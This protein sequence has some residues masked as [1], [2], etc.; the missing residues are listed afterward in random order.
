[1]DLPT[2][3]KKTLQKKFSKAPNM[4]SVNTDSVWKVVKEHIKM[5]VA[6]REQVAWFNDFYLDKIQNG[7][8]YFISTSNLKRTWIENNHKVLIKKAL[9]EATG[10]NLTISIQIHK[11]SFKQDTAT[12]EIL[13][14]LETKSPSLFN[15]TLTKFRKFKEAQNKAGLRPEYTMD[16]FVVGASNSIAFASANAVVDNPGKVYNPVFIYGKTGVGKTHLMQAVGNKLLKNNSSLKIKYCSAEQF[17]ED[18]ITAIR[19]NSTDVFRKEYR[20]LDIWLIDD[21]QFITNSPKT[22]EE[23]FHTFNAL[24]SQ[25]KQVILVSDT[26]PKEIHGLVERL[27]SRFE[28]GLVVDIQAPDFETRMAILKKYTEQQGVKVPK[29]Y[30]EF[31]ANNIESNIRQLEGAIKKITVQ[32][33]YAPTVFTENDLARILGVDINTKRKKISPDKVINAVANIFELHP[34]EIRGQ[35]RTAYVSLARQTV[36]CILRNELEYPLEKVAKFVNRKDHTTVLHACEKIENKMES[37]SSFVDKVKTCISYL[38][39]NL[40]S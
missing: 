6:Q 34:K 3:Y 13:D 24:Y 37:E 31:I 20:G 21:V 10:Q 19:T 11:P 32:L 23:L 38:E 22:Q 1:M 25:N 14:E 2:E 28:G 39:E 29:E 16:E 30:M 15:P 8:A 4:G 18:F 27:K 26:P 17:K 35:K 12:D 36:M 33:K 5:H 40:S 9:K 7:T